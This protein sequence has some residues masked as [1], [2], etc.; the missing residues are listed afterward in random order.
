MTLMARQGP[1]ASPPFI[2]GPP[3]ADH[4]FTCRPSPYPLPLCPRIRG[5]G[6]E[7]VMRQTPPQLRDVPTFQVLIV[8]LC[9]GDKSSQVRDIARAKALAQEIDE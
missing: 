2:L 9:G 1:R 8:V 4:V 6:G 3:P 7:E 5:V